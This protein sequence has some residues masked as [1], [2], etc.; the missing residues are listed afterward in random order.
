MD[1]IK[2]DSVEAF[3]SSLF[4]SFPFDYNGDR[5]KEENEKTQKEKGSIGLTS[6]I[7]R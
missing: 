1:D 3:N 6:Q 4:G 5:E 7:V 2:I